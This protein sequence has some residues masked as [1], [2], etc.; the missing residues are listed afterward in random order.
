MFTAG[1]FKK[2]DLNSLLIIF[3]IL[4]IISSS[5]FDILIIFSSIKLSIFKEILIKKL[6]IVYYLTHLF[7]KSAEEQLN[8]V[9]H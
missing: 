9:L 8:N 1:L 2:I 3:F 4:L 7:V 5:D 6:S